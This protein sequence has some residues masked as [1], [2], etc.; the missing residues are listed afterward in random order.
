MGSRKFMDYHQGQGKVSQIFES[1][2]SGGV[3]ADA[4]LD[5]A[6]EAASRASII[7]NLR[8]LVILL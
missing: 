4:T 3:H 8:I 6:R 5:K 2:Q 7:V 1:L